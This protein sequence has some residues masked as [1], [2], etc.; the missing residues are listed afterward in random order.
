MPIRLKETAPKI[1]PV[2]GI[3]NVTINFPAYIKIKLPIEVTIEKRRI[4]DLFKYNFLFPYSKEM[5]KGVKFI[6]KHKINADKK[7]I[8][9]TPR[10]LF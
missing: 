3:K 10:K 8:E 1:L 4:I 6:N 9:T 7:F 5:V 2:L